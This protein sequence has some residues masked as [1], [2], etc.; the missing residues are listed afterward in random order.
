[1]PLGLFTWLNYNAPLLDCAVVEGRRRLAAATVR[2]LQEASSR[3]PD[4]MV[5][6]QKLLNVFVEHVVLPHLTGGSSSSSSGDVTGLVT[7]TGFIQ[8]EQPLA[9]P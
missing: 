4:V 8:G 7:A 6:L 2:L 1:M 9:H 5:S 3:Q